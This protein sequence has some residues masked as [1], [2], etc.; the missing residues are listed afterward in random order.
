MTLL[1]IVLILVAALACLTAA[2]QWSESFG[3]IGLMWFGH[4]VG[5]ILKIAGMLIV[6]V[7]DQK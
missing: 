7:L 5:E 6:A 1:L 3:F 4:V 2:W